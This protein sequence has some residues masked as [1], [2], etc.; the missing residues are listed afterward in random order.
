MKISLIR[1]FLFPTEGSSHRTHLRHVSL[2]V[3]LCPQFVVVC[4]HK[5]AQ[6]G[7]QLPE[8]YNR[9][10]ICGACGGAVG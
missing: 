5:I 2:T 8:Y 10:L 3:I 7:L 9:L 6:M 4:L 1:N